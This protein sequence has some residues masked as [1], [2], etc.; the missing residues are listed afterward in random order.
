MA[1]D[2]IQRALK[3]WREGLVGLTKSNRLVK[4]NAPKSSSLLIDSPDMNEIWARFAKEGHQTF[5]GDSPRHGADSSQGTIEPPSGNFLHS[6]RPDLEVGTVLRNLMR[7]GQAEYLDRGLSVL[8]IAYGILDWNDE[9]G[10]AMASPILLQPVELIPEGPRGKPRVKKATGESVL[11]P[12]L[13]LRL[14][15][16]GIDLPTIDDL[17][18]EITPGNVLIRVEA[19]LKSG[20]D[21]NGWQI[22][23][24]THIS[25]FSFAKE[26]MFKDLLD[27][28]VAILEHPVVRAL[29]TANPTE[30]DTEFQFD[31]IDPSEIDRLAPPEATPLVLDADSSQR[32]AVAA[33]VAGKSFVMDGPPGTGKSQTIANMIGALMHAGKSVLFV[34]EKIAALDVVHNRLDSRGLGSYL[35]ELHSH[36][37]S[38]KE[39]AVELL[40][41]LDTIPGPPAGMGHVARSAAKDRRERLNNYAA[42]MNEVREPLMKSLH[43]VLGILAQHAEVAAAPTPERPPLSLTDVDFAEAQREMGKLV[44]AWAPAAQ[45]SSYLWRDAVDETSLEIRLYKADAALKKLRQTVN[46][47]ADLV[48]AFGLTRPSDTMKLVGL[49]QHQHGVQLPVSAEPWLTADEWEP[50][51]EARRSLGQHI[52]RIQESE[53]EIVAAAGLPW[54][55]LPDPG[56]ITAAP[57]PL[58]LPYE[59]VR[60]ANVSAS[61]LADTL[62]KFESE[63]RML[64]ERAA[65]VSALSSSM[66]LG[67]ISTFADITTVARIVELRGQDLQP[68][69]TWFTPSG[70][71]QAKN[72]ANALRE[73]SLGLANAESRA[74]TV[75]SPEALKAPLAE[76][77]D[78]FTNLHRGLKKWSKNY[79]NDKEAVASLL[80]EAIDVK[81]GIAHLSDAVAWAEANQA[82]ESTAARH[83]DVLGAH[84][85]GQ[86]TNFDKLDAA[87]AMVEKVQDLLG[88]EVS[89]QTVSYFLRDVSIR[90]HHDIMQSVTHDLETWKATLAPTPALTGRPELLLGTIEGAVAWLRAH[91]LPM[92][93]ALER[94][95]I[96][97]AASPGVQTMYQ[98]DIIIDLIE[99]A[100]NAHATL[101]SHAETYEAY[102]GDLY[103]GDETDLPRLDAVL[104]WAEEMRLM[105]GGAL[106]NEQTRALAASHPVET[107]TTVYDEWVNASERIV[108]AFAPTR[109]EE[110]CQ[111][112]DDYGLAVSLL[113]DFRADTTGQQTWF[114]YIAAKKALYVHGLDAAVEFCLEQRIA[115][116]S[117]PEVLTKALLRSWTEAIIN[118]DDRLMP[119]LASDRDAL[120]E[121]YRKLDRQLIENA[122]TDIIETV[123]L[124]RPANTNFGEPGVIRREGSK[125][126]RHIPV[127]ELIDRTRNVTPA[128][129]PVFMM[130]PLAVSHYLPSDATFDVV[131]F[132]EA[133][134]VSPGDAIN[135]IYRGSALILAG[136]DKQLP[137]TSFFERITDDEEEDDTD[138]KDFQSVLELAKASGAF[139]NL[140]LRWHYRSRHEG[141]I[142]FSNYKFY[143]GKLITFPSARSEGNQLGVEF[144]NVGGTY[145][146]GGG[147]SN[148]EEAKAVA[149]HVIDHYTHRPEMTLGVVTFSVAQADAV[150]DALDAARE[151]R[152]DLDRHFD[153][154]D[155]LAGFFIRSLE[156][157]QGDERDVIIFSVGYGPDEAGKVGTNFGVLNKDKGW[158]RLNVGITRARERV[159]VVA[160]MHADDIP[161]SANENVEYLRNYLDYAEKGL[162]TLAVPYSETGL[163]PESPFEDSVIAAIRGWGYTVEPQVGAGGFRIDVGV[164]HPARPGKF[165]LGVEC[166]GYQYHSAPAARDR[167]RLRDMLLVGLGWR[168]HRI[169]G[170]AWHRNRPE[171]EARL[172]AAIE[173]A[174]IAVDEER[175]AYHDP[176]AAPIVETIESPIVTESTWTTPYEP[177]EASSW[178]Y[179]D[180]PGA[181][182]SHVHMTDAITALATFEGPI[183]LDV[184]YERLRAWWGV[185]RVGAKIRAN[186]DRAIN[187]APIVRNGDFLDAPNRTVDRVRVPANGVN[188]R[189]EHVP[190][191][192]LA[193]ATALLV[194]DVG[195]ASRAEIVQQVSRTF[196]WA[197]QGVVVERRVNEAVDRALND[198]QIVERNGTLS[199]AT[200]GRQVS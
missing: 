181:Q 60:L 118:K 58:N 28:E 44:R 192:E 169:W 163:E 88:G 21:F 93:Q 76:L 97:A 26:A 135:C 78:R 119:L 105:A 101:S 179:W 103:T 104:K 1:Q 14:K 8:Y 17:E 16:F 51:R 162:R 128:I 37:T 144:F 72:S 83:G 64:E 90:Q 174:I 145:R 45:G 71:A 125:G 134:Q 167:D 89:P 84:W 177:A 183:H 102:F 30:Q 188:R 112:L 57:A 94:I 99:R 74:A 66:G 199:P 116:A 13:A 91:V 170:T 109:H 187:L 107:L 164:R 114:D 2:E 197:R 70:L 168:L 132:D 171:E 35:L 186:I 59:P 152:R 24:H 65:S 54:S 127:R 143:E 136:D 161:P 111:E 196:G 25:T 150:Q 159:K 20:K 176:V 7:K 147:A 140:G 146:R 121:E 158:R 142:A 47:N 41:T 96:V 124:R 29:A 39:V 193:L 82:F 63:A 117:I 53:E 81:T 165:V 129:K 106:T 4:F 49:L 180:E 182:G 115:S 100:K 184:A 189:V 156:A 19:A 27:N 154:T 3:S 62:E 56:C 173:A 126:K 42:A 34:S 139:N 175:V 40:R 133:S 77:Q 178:E 33:A 123:N 79:R 31:P 141:L 5:R 138:I 75:F 131:I 95:N 155:R 92:R 80:T 73:Q 68:H 38:R 22:K 98:A 120:V 86:N 166:D 108:L 61:L 18:G 191:E 149:E 67:A 55:L 12:A 190:I 46:L 172:K 195:A 151:Q 48:A 130:S 50:I 32:A 153:G 23:S 36:K 113:D 10:T 85:A 110:L 200:V 43:D 9:D 194:K 137:P 160:S 157:V 69:R 52:D 198:E 148:P 15:D 122:T 6:P 87:L 185:G 11:N